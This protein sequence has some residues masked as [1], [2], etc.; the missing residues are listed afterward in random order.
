MATN[1]L[2]F[3]TADT[4]SKV[5]DPQASCHL[6]DLGNAKRLVIRHGHNLRFCYGSKNWLVWDDKRFK[7]DT[8]NEVERCAKETALS[9]HDEE[10]PWDYFDFMIC[11][12]LSE[13]RGHLNAMV[14]LAKSE[15]SI[16]VTPNLLDADPWLL[17][18]NN[19]ALD[20]RIGKL[21]EHRREDLGLDLHQVGQRTFTSKLLSMPSTQRSQ[22]CA[23]G[24]VIGVKD[25]SNPQTIRNLDEHRSIF[26]ID[27]LPC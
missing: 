26:D 12:N 8:T 7:V 4:P 22:F 14:E 19:G 3:T 20:L 15:L 21:R 1:L 11:A 27:D 16:P 5:G 25:G 9:I 18:C 6:S 13:S 2:A 24:P 17:N 10:T 23:R